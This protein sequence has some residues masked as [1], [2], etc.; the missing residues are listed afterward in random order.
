MT[1]FSTW[2][3]DL[4]IRCGVTPDMVYPPP[5]PA[6]THDPADDVAGSEVSR[7]LHAVVKLQEGESRRRAAHILAN[8]IYWERAAADYLDLIGPFNPPAPSEVD[9]EEDDDGRD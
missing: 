7:T 3:E 8:L 2:A 4:A 6:D 1:H 5:R 9:P